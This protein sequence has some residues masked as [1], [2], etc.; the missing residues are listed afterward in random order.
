MTALDA[1][2]TWLE[3]EASA[4][5]GSVFL[6]FVRIGAILALLPMFGDRSIPARIRLVLAIGLSLAIAPAIPER[7]VFSVPGLGAEAM[8]GLLLGAGFRAFVAALS[9]A[10]AIAAQSTSLSQLFAGTDSEPSPAMSHLL[11][12]GGIALA[13]ALALDVAVIRA[14]VLSYEVL[15]QGRFPMAADMAGWGVARLGH[16][17]GLGLSLAAPFVIGGL[18]YNIATGAINRAMPTLMVALVGAPALTLGALVLLALAAPVIL[19]VWARSWHDWLQLPF[20][21]P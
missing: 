2:L 6:V 21:S 10:G 20:S 18:L 4:V 8:N 12:M 15:P 7:A 1:A 16:A 17:F 5:G 3:H 14:I 13:F 9:M 11:H 19:T